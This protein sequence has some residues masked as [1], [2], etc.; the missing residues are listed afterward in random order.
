MTV[1]CPKC[2][3][4]N[5]SDSKFCKECAAPLP[6]LGIS[7]TKT[8]KAAEEEL[9]SSSS[10]SG[11][12]S[13]EYIKQGRFLPG[14]ILAGRYRIVG[15][16]GKGGMGEVYRADDIKLGQAVAL[17][18]LPPQ[19]S[20]DEKQLKYFHN[21][22]RLAR[23]V[24]HPN[25][26]R[27]YDIGEVEG[28]YF[29]SMEYVDGEDLAKLLRRIGRLPKDKG[30]EIAHQLCA[31]LAA[32]HDQGILHR[33]LKPS[34]VM[35]DGRGRV[36]I[37]DFGLALLAAE[38]EASEAG[39]G[40]PAYMAPEQLIN[41]QVTEQSDIYS[42]G[43]IL[44]E[45]FTGRPAYK[46]DNIDEL[47]KLRSRSTPAALSAIVPDLDPEIEKGILMCLEE[48]TKDRPRSALALAAVFPGGDPLAAALAAG[49]TPS[50]EM[51][52][53]ARES[54]YLHPRY[55][56][57]WLAALLLGLIAAVFLAE[58]ATVLGRA[59]LTE[60]PAVLEK[61]ARDI[62]KNLGYDSQPKDRAYGF[63]YAKDYLW[64]LRIKASMISKRENPNPKKQPGIY[65]WYRQSMNFLFPLERYSWMVTED[66]PPQ[67][68]PGMV[69]I[70]LKGNG[71]LIEFY[72]APQKSV[73]QSDRQEE[74]DWGSLFEYSGLNIRRF[75][76]I[77]DE[78]PK[79]LFS[80]ISDQHIMW[81]GISPKGE[82]EVLVEGASYQGKPVY[83]TIVEGTPIPQAARL[84]IPPSDRQPMRIEASRAVEWTFMLVLLIAAALIARRGLRMGRSDPKGAVR[85]GLFIFS[86]NSIAWF[87]EASHVPHFSGELALVF[88]GLSSVMFYSVYFGVV[89]LAFEPYIRRFWPKLLISWNRFA[90]GRF[91][92]PSVGRDLLVGAAVGVWFW[93]VLEFLTVLA[94]DWLGPVPPFWRTIPGTLLGGR[95]MLAVSVFCLTA[96]GVSLVYLLSLVLLRILLKKWWLWSF[97]FIFMGA[98][99]FIV[100]DFASIARWLSAAALM[101]SLLVI[102]T[103][104]GLLA[105]FAFFY[106]AYILSDFPLTSDPSS[107]YWGST[108]FALGIITAI[109]I[110]GFY[111]STSKRSLSKN[112]AVLLQ[113]AYKKT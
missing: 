93:P 55:A 54:G 113:K 24:S 71:D 39:V 6:F 41:G 58:K 84:G 75:T 2:H 45:V 69:G 13:W 21:E 65:F 88:A 99:F 5:P 1:K 35:L 15:L 64:S 46:A 34:N 106:A 49:E 50:P 37:T 87:F 104:L 36:R 100:S 26:C 78:I 94:P 30:L 66:D 47:L 97:V 42:L 40:T 14:F 73:E 52:A 7:V 70:R 92:D 74:A 96:L 108:L 31:G 63:D 62:I 91:R 79:E 95:H 8:F 20:K 19:F 57:A 103:R 107:W 83:F 89:Y 38:R 98:L 18:L 16:L 27:V 56:I 43:L 22:V 11:T 9:S 48:E 61:A 101:I 23:Q 28:Q 10:D 111:T 90:I 53:A 72:A 85:L 3:T 112:S 109:G 17:K 33:D 60:K 51:V 77:S 82:N 4:E 25:V 29:L 59:D 76:K 68:L 105:A 12:S 44:Y 67:I 102:I 80:R 81:K 32:A 110:Y 86:L